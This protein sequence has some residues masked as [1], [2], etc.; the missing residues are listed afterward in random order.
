MEAAKNPRP[1][2]KLPP[3][4]PGITLA[5]VFVNRVNSK[6]GHAI[7]R[8]VTGCRFVIAVATPYNP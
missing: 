1:P 7:T 4:F 2:G 6:S 8:G 5:I 3:G